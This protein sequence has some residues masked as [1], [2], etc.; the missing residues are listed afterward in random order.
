ML[1]LKKN[2]TVVEEDP[3]VDVEM[4]SMNVQLS[5]EPDD[6]FV[7]VQKKAKLSSE[8]NVPRDPQLR[9]KGVP[10]SL[11]SSPELH[12]KVSAGVSEQRHGLLREGDLQHG[13]LSE[14]DQ[15]E[16]LSQGQ[17]RH[18]LISEGEQQLENA[19]ISEKKDD[20]VEEFEQ[21]DNIERGVKTNL[22]GVKFMMWFEIGIEGKEPI[23]PEEEDWGGLIEFGFDDKKFDKDVE[24]YFL[25]FEDECSAHKTCA[26]R[27]A[28]LLSH[29]RDSLIKP[30]SHD[31]RN[32]VDILEKYGDAHVSDSGWREVDIEEWFSD[33]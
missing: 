19:V 20:E 2:D 23:D 16:K 32:V 33:E 22:H 26:G 15:L 9:V 12:H 7:R 24:D 8:V 4:A 21:Q 11:S 13:L 17:I 5:A 31:P 1:Q 25:M 27:V 6:T 28:G 30:P 18:G 3:S 29:V 14:S 10:A